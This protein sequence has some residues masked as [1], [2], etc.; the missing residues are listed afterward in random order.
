MKVP[1]FKVQII[2]QFS[3]GVI[4]G[5][6]TRRYFYSE[7]EMSDFM[8]DMHYDSTVVSISI[9]KVTEEDKHDYL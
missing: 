2:R 1:M 4:V 7:K 8:S 3:N 9:N 5:S 6:N